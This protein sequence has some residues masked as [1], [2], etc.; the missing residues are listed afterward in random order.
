MI[1]GGQY[2]YHNWTETA[3]V[4]MHDPTTSGNGYNDTM[5][6]WNTL[7]YDKGLRNA[8]KL[9]MLPVIVRENNVQHSDVRGEPYGVYQINGY[10]LPIF[11]SVVSA[12]GVFLTMKID[13]DADHTNAYGPVASGTDGFNM[14][15]RQKKFIN[16]VE[17]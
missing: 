10:R 2:N 1:K 16:G 12:S 7:Q 14:W 4:Y 13:N 8:G 3:A 5:N 6:W 9:V 11:G 15:E 17:Y